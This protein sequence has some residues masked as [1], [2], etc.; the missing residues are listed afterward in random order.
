MIIENNIQQGKI[1]L[2]T[3]RKSNYHVVAFGQGA[4]GLCENKLLCYAQCCHEVHS[5]A[6]LYNS[7]MHKW[8]ISFTSL[9]GASKDCIKN[10]HFKAEKLSSEE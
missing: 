8:P 1:P 2:K 4:I 10:V 6:F 7:S 3:S 5:K 9:H